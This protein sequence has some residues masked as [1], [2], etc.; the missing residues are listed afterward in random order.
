MEY[1]FV[2]KKMKEGSFGDNALTNREK[3]H[4]PVDKII[5]NI[6]LSYYNF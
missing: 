1:K 5:K 3:S 4:R 6:E 2:T